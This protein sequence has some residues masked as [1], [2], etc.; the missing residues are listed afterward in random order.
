MYS[1]GDGLPFSLRFIPYSI[2]SATVT[3]VPMTRFNFSPLTNFVYIWSK[4][5]N[6][7]PTI[8]MMLHM[9]MRTTG[10]IMHR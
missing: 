6:A 1:S 2:P 7:S 8:M 10:G 9:L 3:A 4:T 5:N